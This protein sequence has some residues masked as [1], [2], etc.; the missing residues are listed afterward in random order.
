MESFM[1]SAALVRSASLVLIAGLSPA[2]AGAAAPAPAAASAPTP[3]DLAFART[4]CDGAARHPTLAPVEIDMAVR[5]TIAAIEDTVRS[6]EDLDKAGP[7]LDAPQARVGDLDAVPSTEL[8][9]LR[10]TL[11]AQSGD[12]V[13][14]MRYRTLSTALFTVLVGDGDGTTPE[15]AFKPCLIPNEYAFVRRVLQAEVTG[16]SLV[17]VEDRHYDRLEVTF[18]DG[19]K[20][21]FFFDVTEL[22]IRNAAAFNR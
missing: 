9:L 20:R 21:G 10:A 13:A 3:Q 18:P 22:F 11:A 15:T 4:S 2:L 5:D 6:A 14:R 16:Q 19:T 8:Q 17:H 1:R 12:E 7:L